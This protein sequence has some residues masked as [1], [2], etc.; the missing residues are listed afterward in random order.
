MTKRVEVLEDT[1]ALATALGLTSTVIAA[2]WMT[3]F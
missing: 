3:L 2:V 1:V